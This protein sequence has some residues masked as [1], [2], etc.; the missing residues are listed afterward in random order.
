M[1]PKIVEITSALLVLL[2]LGP[3]GHPVMESVTFDELLAA[4]GGRPAARDSGSCPADVVTFGRVATD[5]RKVEQGDLFWALRGERR[6]GHNFVAEAARRGAAGCVIESTESISRGLPAAVVADTIQGL[7]DF[8]HWY[9][10]RRDALVVGVTGSV[11]KTTTREMIYSVLRTRFDGCRS[12]KNYNNHIGLPLSVLEMHDRHEFAVLEMGASHVGE[13]RELAAIASPE[14]GVVTEIGVSH[15]EGFGGVAQI[16][17]AKG[18]LVDALPAA[19]FAVLNGDDPH[20]PSLA[21]RARCRVLTV[22]QQSHNTFRASAVEAAGREL[23]FQVDGGAFAVRAAGRHHLTAAL[24][25]VAIARELGLSTQQI[26]EGLLQFSPVDGRCQVRELGTGTLIDD[27][28]NANPTSTQAACRMLREW[29]SPGRRILVL[30]DMAELGDQS[31]DWHQAIGRTAAELRI[32]RLA[33]YGRY[34]ADV[35]R[36]ALENGMKSDQLAECHTLDVLLAVLDCW[37]EPGD[38]V[39]VKGSRSMRME[40][41]SEWLVK[42]AE[43]NKETLGPGEGTRACA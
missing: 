39:L 4:T 16:V 25:S 9:R 8:A 41:V 15:L 38:V 30:G 32:D 29:N 10:Q 26:T 18:E 24:V 14:I 40:R 11:G 6:D 43:T 34:A 7:K 21:R 20:C 33:A 13:I 23:R 3:A 5:S 22:G 1:L 2:A 35:T 12:Q 27:T 17:E 31:A 42:N 19:G 36:S 37:S 28:Y